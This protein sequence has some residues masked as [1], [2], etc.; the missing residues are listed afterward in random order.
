[1]DCDSYLRQINTPELIYAAGTGAFGFAVGATSAYL[2]SGNVLGTGLMLSLSAVSK[3]AMLRFSE[4]QVEACEVDGIPYDLA[5]I[6]E[7]C[8]IN[9]LAVSA[10]IVG[11]GSS[12]SNPVG[13]MVECASALFLAY[14]IPRS[15]SLEM[16]R[17]SAQER[18]HY[19]EKAISQ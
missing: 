1:M 18:R 2:C 5:E 13:I 19:R 11:L 14:T 16:A 17:E 10:A 8:S 9:N 3:Y 6:K 15:E 7:R 12:I 4:M